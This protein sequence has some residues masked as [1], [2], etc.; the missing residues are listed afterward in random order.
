[1]TDHEAR[2]VAVVGIGALLPDA[3]DAPSFWKNLC[4][5]RYS[6]SEVPPDRWSVED[7]YDPDPSAPDKTYS[8]IGGWVR[9]YAFDWQRYKV[10]PRVASAMDP[11]QQWAITISAQALADYGFPGRALDLE[12]TGVVLGAAMG[13][14]L[15]YL[16]TLRVMFPEFRHAL[17]GV[18]AF[19]HLAP[20]LRRAIVERWHED[21]GRHLPAITEDSMPGELANIIAGRVANVLNLRG[22]NFTTDAACASSLAAVDAAVDL[23]SE[24]HC[25]AVITGGVDRNMGASTFVKFCKIGALSATGSRPFGEG[26]DGFVMGEGAAVFLL[27]RLS[28]AERDGD[29]VYAVVRGVGASSD[30][31]GKGITAPNPA[32]QQLAVRRAWEDAGLDPATARMV[33]A[34][35]T[36]T[37]VGDVVEVESLAGSFAAA[38]RGAIALGSVKSNLGHL[39]AAAGAAGL[40]KAVLALHHRVLPPT[41]HAARPNPSID[42]S[43]TPFALET[44]LRDWPNGTPRRAGV[45][46]YGF[47]GT[48][49]HV[50]LE[51]HVPGML[52]P[53]RRATVAVPAHA[54]ASGGAVRA[55]PAAA[56]SKRP[57][58]GLLALGEATVADLRARLGRELGRAREGAVPEPA[59]PAQ[60]DL[61]APER[62][63]LDFGGGA[64]LVD[65]LERARR[66]LEADAPA[67]WKALGNQGVFRG[68]GPPAGKL[69][70]LFPGQGSQFVN[71][72]RA[73]AEREP[74]VR[75]VFDEADAVL[76]PILGRRLSSFL[77][78]DPADAAAMA[79]AE[80]DLKQT[81]VT[82]PAVLTVDNAL[83]VL[84]GE[85]GIAPDYVMGHSLGEYG[86]LVA[87][88]AMPFADALEASA[89]RGREMTRVSLA[90][91]GWMAAVMGPLEEIERTLASLDGYVVTANLNSASQAVIGGET[92]AVQRAMEALAA[93]GMEVVRLPV[94][95]AFHTR[96]VAPAAGPLGEVLDR[97][98]LSAP[99]VPV[100]A[101]V[102]GDRYPTA[103]REIRD[104]LVRQIASPVQ[105]VR[106]LETLWREGV[107]TFVEVGPKKALKGFVDDVLGARGGLVSLFTN[108]PKLGDLAAFNQALC[109]VLAAGHAPIAGR[110]PSVGTGDA[111]A[112]AA[113]PAPPSPSTAFT[114]A[115]NGGRPETETVSNTSLEELVQ[116]LTRT[117]AAIAP[118]PA[119]RDG[120]DGI[121]DRNRPPAGSVV[122]TGCGL[123]LPG[124][125]KPVMAPE[126]VDR[127]LRGEQLIDLIPARFRDLMV[128]KH[129]TRVVKTAEG[130]G[131]FESIDDSADVLKL[132]GRP[133]PFDLAAEYGVPEKLV[134][135]LDVTTQLAMA[136]GIDALREAG[137]PLVQAWRRTSKGTFLPDRWMLPEAM[138]DET[139]VIFASAFPGIDSFADELR[140]YYTNESRLARRATLDELRRATT[141]PSALGEIQR[142]LAQV[143]DELR[144][145]PY[146]FE[147]RFLLRI[148]PMGHSQF[149]EYVGARGPSTLVNAA[150]ASTA[151]AISLAE[152][153][154]RTGR[155]R[156]VIVIAADDPTSDNLM[157]W[158]GAGFLATGAA[159]TDD[160]IEDAAIP[161]DRRRHGMIVGMGAAA[162]VVES[163]DA[164][165]ERGMR[166]IVELLSSETRNSAFHATR[167]DVDH[168]ASVVESL[169]RSAERRFGLDRRAIAPETVFMSHETYT[170]ARGGSASA[171]VAALRRV[172]GEAANAIVVSNT[173]GLTGHAMG[174]G[175]EDV[176]AVK[177]LEH[178]IVPPVPNFREEDPDL[179]PLNLSRGGRYPVNY[180]IHLA[181]G[182]G[183][184]IALTLTRRIPGGAERI[185]RPDVHRRW[186][187]AVTGVDGAET[188]V[189]NRTLRVVSSGAPARAPQ[190]AAWAWGTGPARR[191]PAPPLAA[192]SPAAGR[193][194]SAVVTAPRPAPAIAPPRAA[195]A[196]AAPPA[197]PAA[198]AAPAA[199]ASAP[200][201]AKATPPPAAVA[202]TP[203]A[204]PSPPVRDGEGR[205]DGAANASSAADPITARV[206]AIVSEK[207]GYPAD[208]LDLDLDLEAD[209]GVDTVK[210]AETFAAVRAEWSI[211]RIENLR[212]RDFPTLRHVV[213]FV[214]QHRPDLVA[215]AP[216]V[217]GGAGV[218]AAA[219]AAPGPQRSALSPPA[220]EGRGEGAARP[221][222]VADPITARVVAIVSEKTGYPADLLDLDLDLEADLGVDTVKQAE[223]FAA[224]RAEW[225][226]PRIEN[227]RLRDFPTLR[228]VVGFVRQH[229]PDLVATAP[230]VARGAGEG[231]AAEAA[232]GAR[233]SAVSQGDGEDRGEG[234][235]RPSP[236]ADPVT[237]RVVAIV[238][239]K[240]G[241]PADLLD[242]DLDLE[243]DLGVDTVKQ[244][245]TF[246]AVRAEW[247]IPRVENLKLRDFPTL[248]HVIG[249]VRQHRPD[250]VPTAPSLPAGA[251]PSIAPPPAAPY[252]LENADRAPR[253]V[254]TPV[255][256]PPLDLCKATRVALGAGTRVVVAHGATAGDL[257]AKL[258][259]LGATVLALDARQPAAAIE[260]TLRG[261]LAE[262]PIHGVFWVPSLDP[263]AHLD[264]M[265]LDAFRERT[266][267]VVKNLASAMRVLY[268]AVAPTG[269]FLVAATRLGGMLG[270]GVEGTDAPLGGAVQGFVKA[271]KRERRDA[272]VKVV[273][274]ATDATDAEIAAALVAEALVD[275]G[276]VEVGRREGTRWSIGLEDRPVAPS[277]SIGLG[278][279]TVFVVTGAAG[280]ITSAIVADLAAASGGTFHL[281]DLVAPPSADDRHVALF[282]DARDRLKDA[283]IAEAKAR[284]EK[285]T[286]VAI[287]RQLMA[288]E[289]QD[290]ALRALE[291]VR[292]AGGTAHWHAVDLLDAASVDAAVQAIRKTSGRIDV[293]VH[294]GGIEISRALPDKPDEEWARVFDVKAEGFFSLLHAA[295]E[296]PLGATVVFS[297]VAGRFGNSGQTDYSAANALLCEISRWLR[298]SR[299]DTRAIAIDWTAWGGIGMATR[300]SIPKIMEAAGIDMLA[301]EVGIP[302]VR[303]ELLSGAADEIVVGLRLGTLVGEWDT[304]GGLDLD[305]VQARLGARAHPFAMI[306]KVAG[307]LL[308]DGLVVDTRLD[309][310]EQ[311]FL[312]DH[313][314]DGVPVLPGVMGAE[315]FAEMASVLCPDRV[316]TG[317]G[318]VEYLSPFKFHRTRPATLHLTAIGRPGEGD[319]VLVRVQLSSL[320]QPKPGMPLQERV[321]FR[322]NVVMERE[323]VAARNVAFQPPKDATLEAEAIYR[324]YFHGPAYRVLDGVRLEEGGAIGVM[325]RELPPN[326]KEPDAA[327][328][329]AP[330]LL[331]LCFQTA[332][333]MDIVERDV[334]GLPAGIGSVTLYRTAAPPGAA[335]FAE[336]RRAGGDAFDARVVDAEGEVYLELSGYRAVALPDR[337]ERGAL[338][339]EKGAVA[340]STGR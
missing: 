42:F 194:G 315:A 201:A 20:E 97:L 217:P 156:R 329:V 294:A 307:A 26:A 118:S 64:D 255:L 188:E 215:T 197:A 238:S 12:R 268:Q 17:E 103:R 324:V 83:R 74:A 338:V 221:S 140:R 178:G 280:G 63:V 13:G 295:R 214:R 152:D 263:E 166:G 80:E 82:Q 52:D 212:L 177:I 310:E 19:S 109:G 291:S 249:F 299:P 233:R 138:R 184:Q 130:D 226:I 146:A 297:S 258:A 296:M 259:D 105:W 213:G 193:S 133:G 245:E 3:P 39:K 145:E 242:L 86:A 256:R 224:V 37:K 102:T 336:V 45:S 54:P 223:T 179:G 304:T 210:Q 79:R 116:V 274:F 219:E 200:P 137:I 171:E 185:D 25:D 120:A 313:R 98:R 85:Y 128:R 298:R 141:D 32:G 303:R 326:A 35:G 252:P 111:V 279:E 163:Q 134:E 160:R 4:D 48:N 18:E 322:A 246:A 69:A 173:K 240:T 7:Y 243:A 96:I 104:M 106:G 49:F 40:L 300:G 283:L 150:C 75:A 340:S 275:P 67:A 92:E 269:T 181:A 281:L 229:R 44:E 230:S 176:I 190:P 286:P 209:L 95:H 320:L 272:L 208:L 114:A 170:P 309:P 94:S 204:R 77:F 99:R 89:A 332:G 330:R 14:E 144:R 87:A 158:I 334:F 306:G 293:L 180:A 234:A 289:R 33:E 253:R 122:I 189:A 58:R 236:I 167:L 262:G 174:V 81:A 10:P 206:V 15:H 31:K 136:A 8:K 6:I 142:Q 247:S 196:I 220:G 129:V 282:R 72:G 139:G 22:P 68:A 154:I 277:P 186:L 254:A 225:S 88:G 260:S 62:V 222:P 24:R 76:E 27:K 151:Q 119:T 261:W 172:F 278:R 34:H 270:L 61:A 199:V 241:Y 168:V 290:A 21:L 46:A 70:F 211:P 287:D 319:A 251:G 100:I 147:R 302:T 216:S 244:A 153:W 316:V 5:G 312:H 30:G 273:D 331:E 231:P 108:H 257:P 285:P 148:L 90:D 305:E 321:H 125:D 9:G 101:N 311:P 23:L 227:L 276:V 143:D 162:L 121:L 228:H 317:L 132:A 123:G 318:D 57:L 157:E 218:S 165:E 333:L 267:V 203:S 192:G 91:N 71:M 131:R 55:G 195:P 339:G 337:K 284:G 301:P 164:V 38:G 113:P 47:G 11:A 16:T 59:F 107:R 60:A 207:T 187:D 335:L 78:A 126:N 202:S 328:L 308:G 159:A 265:S 43:S 327:E 161:F 115:P 266:R 271:Y 239:E 28:D 155:C 36:S 135:A 288:V 248:R 264:E 169:V 66:A 110:A 93:K 182:F 65:K 29:R 149:G 84:L 237:A 205:G 235:A 175:V 2:A 41:L 51:E 124:P 314:I 198:A 56:A 325:R 117:L 292:A 50:V 127:I 112:A 53:R 73:L 191:A 250:L 232:P 1:M 323:P 183:S